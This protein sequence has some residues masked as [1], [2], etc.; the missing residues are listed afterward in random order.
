VSDLVPASLLPLVS[1]R[2]GDRSLPAGDVLGYFGLALRKRGLPQASVL[3]LAD[4]FA[5]LERNYRS[6]TTAPQLSLVR[7]DF[8]LVNLYL[9]SLQRRNLSPTTISAYRRQLVFFTREHPEGFGAVTEEAIEDW[10]DGR[11]MSAKQRYWWLSMLTNFYKWAVKAEHLETNPAEP[12]RRPQTG[13]GLPRPISDGDLYR[14]LTQAD[15]T[16]RCWLLLGAYEGLR[17]QEIA[18]LTREDVEDDHG[19]LRVVYGKGGK[20]RAVPLHPEVLEALRSLP[21]PN[22]GDLFRRPL[23]SKMTADYLAHRVTAYLHESG[24]AATVHKLRHWF[25]TSVYRA[26]RDLRLTQ[27][28]LGHSSPT[29]TANYAACDPFLAAPVVRAL[30][31]EVPEVP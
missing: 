10:L 22:S 23:G 30:S 18:G 12:I 20:E 5:E 13:R 28:L 27:E 9:R 4:V 24:S 21:M 2:V 8:D 7:S 1:L 17:A 11:E 29:V 31:V 26:T 19:V 16:M 15:P 6:Q 3:T 25:A 14:A